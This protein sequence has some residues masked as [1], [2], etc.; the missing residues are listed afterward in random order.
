MR[1]RPLWAFG[2][3]FFWLAVARPVWAQ[4]SR[5]AFDVPPIPTRADLSRVDSLYVALDP[6][7]SLAA[8]E[9]LV[10]ADSTD[11]EA[12]LACRAGSAGHGAPSYRRKRAGGVVPT[13]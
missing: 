3:T 1:S 12:S 9:A 11:E 6:S 5:P 8:A 4:A 7:G 10:A 13:V 2:L